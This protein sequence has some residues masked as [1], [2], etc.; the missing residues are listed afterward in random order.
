MERNTD[1]Y[2]PKPPNGG[3]MARTANCCCHCSFVNSQVLKQLQ[4]RNINVT[5]NTTVEF[6]KD[7]FER[8]LGLLVSKLTVRGEGSV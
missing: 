2:I 3:K 1:I 7:E 6:D 4:N 8:Q 5:I